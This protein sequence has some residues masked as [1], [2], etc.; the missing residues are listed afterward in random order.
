[1][2]FCKDLLQNVANCLSLEDR[3]FKGPPSSKIIGT[4][5]GVSAESYNSSLKGSEFYWLSLSNGYF[6]EERF[7]NLSK[8]I[9]N[10]GFPVISEVPLDII[11]VLKTSKH[12]DSFNYFSSAVVRTYLY[13]NRARWENKIP[14]K[15]VLE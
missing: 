7:N 11:R 1:K 8:I 3:V 10:I 13:Y 12:K 2:N 5:S 4:V 9:G 14:R 6:E 15:E